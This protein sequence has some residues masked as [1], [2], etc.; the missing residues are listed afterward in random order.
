MGMWIVNT[1]KE[2]CSQRLTQRRKG[3]EPD[4]ILC[5]VLPAGSVILS[6]ALLRLPFCCIVS[7]KGVPLR[8]KVRYF[9]EV[10]NPFGDNERAKVVASSRLARDDDDDDD[11]ND[12][13]SR[14]GDGGGGDGSGG[15]RRS[16]HG[17][18]EPE[19]RLQELGT[20]LRHV[21]CTSLEYFKV[22]E[23]DDANERHL[24][25]TPR[26]APGSQL[27]QSRD[28]GFFLEHVDPFSCTE[29]RRTPDIVRMFDPLRKDNGLSS[30]S[31]LV[32]QDHA[33]RRKLP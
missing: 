20:R 26:S 6:R 19:Q 31:V 22:N 14:G 25:N 30:L 28:L 4:G 7:S 5:L 2:S 33:P 8:P 16:A 1:E 11:E 9:P 15:G 27:F 29:G 21:A 32:P 23:G 10:A 18:K 12:D 3:E 17:L 24:P 13:G